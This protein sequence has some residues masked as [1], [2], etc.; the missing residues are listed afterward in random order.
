MWGRN[1]VLKLAELGCL[2]G[3]VET[4]KDYVNEFKLRCL[5][6]KFFIDIDLASATIAKILGWINEK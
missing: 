3:V 6:Y 5:E 1:Y 2:D 4:D